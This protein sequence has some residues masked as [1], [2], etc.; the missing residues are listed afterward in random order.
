MAE[1][2][3]SNGCR[4]KLNMLFCVFDDWGAIVPSWVTDGLECSFFF[5]LNESS[6]K[7][8]TL[9]NWC[10]AESRGLEIFGWRVILAWYTSCAD[11]DH[12]S[13]DN[14]LNPLSLEKTHSEANQAKHRMDFFVTK[15]TERYFAIFLYLLHET[16]HILGWLFEVLVG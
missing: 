13:G 12:L 6:L 9:P 14:K 10:V 8:I 4:L 7:P 2:R 16:L 15:T 5:L 11:L 3:F 1:I